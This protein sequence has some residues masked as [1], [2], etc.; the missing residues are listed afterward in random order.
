MKKVYDI[1]RELFRQAYIEGLVPADITIALTMPTHRKQGGRRA[2]TQQERAAFLGAIPKHEK[3]LFFAIMLFAGLRPSEVRAL[4]FCDIDRKRREITV[5]KALTRSA[6]RK[7]TKTFKGDRVVPYFAELDDFLPEGEPFDYVVPNRKGGPMT[8]SSYDQMWKAFSNLLHVEM[9]GKMFRGAPQ[10]PYM[11]A[12]DLT[13]YCLRH[14]FCTD[15]EKA[16]VPINIACRIMGHAD[17]S[18]TSRI[19]T[20]YDTETADIASAIMNPGPDTGQTLDK[21]PHKALK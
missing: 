6:Q 16:G 3:G 2:I 18:T 9:G 13:P 15:L 1:I 10:P 12:D 19:Y 5:S 17:V 21:N 14:T 20:H 8:Y 7:D 11:V 4:K